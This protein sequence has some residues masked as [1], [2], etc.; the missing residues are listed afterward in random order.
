MQNILYFYLD[1]KKYSLYRNGNYFHYTKVVDGK[2]TDDL[3]DGEIS[4]IKKA[5]SDV[6]KKPWTLFNDKIVYNKK[7]YIRL[8]NE[9]NY[10]IFFDVTSGTLKNPSGFAL[11]F[12][13]NVYNNQYNCMG[14]KKIE[15]ADYIRRYIKLGS[16]RVSLY[17]S[18]RL[19]IE[20]PAKIKESLLGKYNF[21]INEDLELPTLAGAKKE[22][23]L[24]SIILSNSDIDRLTVSDVLSIYEKFKFTSEKVKSEGLIASIDSNPYLS[25]Q[26]K[27][28]LTS[29]VGAFN[30]VYMHLD[31]SIV[32]VFKNLNI[33][34]EDRKNCD[35]YYLVDDNTITVCDGSKKVN[36]K[37]IAIIIKGFIHSWT[38]H[39]NTNVG[40]TLQDAISQRYVSEYYGYTQDDY[41]RE[42][43]LLTSLMQLI[44]PTALRIFHANLDSDILIGELVKINGNYQMAREFLSLFDAAYMA[45]RIEDISD[46][47]LDFYHNEMA[48]IKRI[49]TEYYQMKTYKKIDANLLV[50]LCFDYEKAVS[51]IFTKY[52]LKKELMPIVIDSFSYKDNMVYFNSK[53]KA[54]ATM[55]I[56]FCDE[57]ER[58]NEYLTI[59]DAIKKDLVYEINGE[60]KSVNEDYYK[61]VDNSVLVPKINLVHWQK[62]TIKINIFDKDFINR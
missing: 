44:S 53:V 32:E 14:L 46:D 20:I 51:K 15:R 25:R 30:D 59:D 41:M 9:D 6:V 29:N 16:N 21:F 18:A 24:E 52:G 13:N 28:I 49:F 55:D 38:R 45:V 47:E 48:K 61:I 35:G 8:V 10:S 7:D 2:E 23:A 27:T 22:E 40:Y 11:K 12:L 5:L 26:E 42:Q 4:L 36:E 54:L 60:Y 56:T 57:V 43:A 34:F 19:G 17:I 39:G 31:A 3:S 50:W 1:R 62:D 33:R 58:Y 37:N